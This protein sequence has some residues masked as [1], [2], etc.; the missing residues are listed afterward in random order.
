M[1][2]RR[3]FKDVT[4][5]FL[6]LKISKI[7]VRKQFCWKSGNDANKRWFD[8]LYYEAM[9]AKIDTWF[10]S[11]SWVFCLVTWNL[12]E[13]DKSTRW[14][15]ISEFRERNF[16]PKKHW[17]EITQFLLQLWLYHRFFQLKNKSQKYQS[18][19]EDDHNNGD[20]KGK[21]TNSVHT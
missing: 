14:N 10:T 11:Y 13:F 8:V 18:N 15:H 17:P 21:N 2:I 3:F 12:S 6:L 19:N 16:Y 5:L 4:C 20:N 7:L 9:R 1:W